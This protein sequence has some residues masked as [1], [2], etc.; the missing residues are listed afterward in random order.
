MLWDLQTQHNRHRCPLGFMKLN[1]SFGEMLTAHS[2]LYCLYMTPFLHFC[3]QTNGP[4]VQGDRTAYLRCLGQS[5]VSL[6]GLFQLL[7]WDSSHQCSSVHCVSN[8]IKTQIFQE[9][10]RF[11]FMA[12]TLQCTAWSWDECYSFLSPRSE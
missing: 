12:T 1:Q 3:V 4:C 8:C 7:V 9:Q 5:I 2:L 11:W 10:R 6:P